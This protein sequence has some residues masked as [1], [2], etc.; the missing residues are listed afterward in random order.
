MFF[1]IAQGIISTMIGS[2]GLTDTMPVELPERM[3][4]LIEDVGL[5]DSIP[6]W[7]VTLY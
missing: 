3:T 2:S 5:L 1:R 7:A 4:E 6:L